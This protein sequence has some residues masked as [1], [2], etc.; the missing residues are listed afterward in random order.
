MSDTRNVRVAESEVFLYSFSVYMQVAELVKKRGFLEGKLLVRALLKILSTR[1]GT[2][3]ICGTLCFGNKWPYMNK[4][5]CISL[6]KRETVI[7]Y[8]LKNWI[9]TPIRLAF[10]FIKI[11]CLFVFFT[12][13]MFSET[14]THTFLHFY[15]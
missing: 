1:L 2:L 5:S 7:Q 9:L 8:W 3:L 13:V 11:L 15:A 4:F 14:S 12:Q 10:A 6:H